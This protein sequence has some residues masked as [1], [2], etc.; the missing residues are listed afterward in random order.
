MVEEIS[1]TKS[2]W[3]W[4]MLMT[5]IIAFGSLTISYAVYTTQYL[6]NMDHRMTVIENKM[7]TP[8]E[9]KD[10]QKTLFQIQKDI[11]SIPT[12]VPPKWFVLQVGKLEAKVDQLEKDFKDHCI[13]DS[14]RLGE[15]HS[16]MIYRS[17]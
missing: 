4:K 15:K 3:A 10:L 9:K 14:I 8:E 17:K 6:M 16:K 1:Q 7:F 12:E 5:I 2:A 11:A 13:R